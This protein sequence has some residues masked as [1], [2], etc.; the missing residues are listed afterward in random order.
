MQG[1]LLEHALQGYAKD[2][3]GSVIRAPKRT[4]R[5]QCMF[6]F[7]FRTISRK[8]TQAFSASFGSLDTCMEVLASGSSHLLVT[9]RT[10]CH[11]E[12]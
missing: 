9:E 3:P 11:A 6:P 2:K 4:L 5:L 8:C 10:A 1:T 7:E 12:Y